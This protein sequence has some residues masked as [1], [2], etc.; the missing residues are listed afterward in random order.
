MV[1]YPRKMANEN[2]AIGIPRS[3][4]AQISAILQD[5]NQEL[6]YHQ[7]KRFK[8][9]LPPTLQIGADAAS[10][11]NILPT[12]SVAEFL[13]RADGRVKMKR[14]KMEIQ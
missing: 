9:Y 11:A 3:S 8:T 5:H 1:T 12:T 2:A 6:M 10:P 4:T 7:Q 14:P 13:A